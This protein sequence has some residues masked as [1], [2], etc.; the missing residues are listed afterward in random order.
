[1]SRSREGV[2]N[3]A[4]SGRDFH[5]DALEAVALKMNMDSLHFCKLALA[6]DIS[7]F[8]DKFD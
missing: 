7:Q 5:P 3:Y 4:E 8:V 1:M 2:G 6:K